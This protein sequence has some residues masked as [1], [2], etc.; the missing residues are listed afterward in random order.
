MFDASTPAQ[1]WTL[2]RVPCISVDAGRSCQ[3]K[4]PAST[5]GLMLSTR[6]PGVPC[7]AGGSRG[8]PSAVAEVNLNAAVVPC[9]APARE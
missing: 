7:I 5:L 1:R 8:D 3:Q 4:R 2:P 6:I 9:S